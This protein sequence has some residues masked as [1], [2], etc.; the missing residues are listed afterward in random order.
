MVQDILDG[1][2]D[3]HFAGL[4]SHDVVRHSLVGAI[5]DAY[6]RWDILSSSSSTR[7]AR[8]AKVVND[9]ERRR[10]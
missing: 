6:A 2:E 4:N 8:E 7:R 5:V 10:S 1:V 3:V 9:R